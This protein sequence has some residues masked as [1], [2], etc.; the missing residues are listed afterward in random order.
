MNPSYRLFIDVCLN[1]PIEAESIWLRRVTTLQ[2]APRNGDKLL[3]TVEETEA[4]LEIELQNVVYDMTNGHFVSDIEDNQM[5]DSYRE[6][7]VLNEAEAIA[8][9]KQHD[10]VRLNFPTGEG[11]P[12]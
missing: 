7:G 8:M 3:F 10:F 9:Y 6:Q 2:F 11:R 12:G 5:V 4:Q 1:K